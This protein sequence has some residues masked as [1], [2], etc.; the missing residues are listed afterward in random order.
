MA[1][2][3]FKAQM[4]DELGTNASRRLRRQGKLP[5]TVYGNDKQAIAIAVD[6]NKFI[7]AERAG[8]LFDNKLQLDIDGKI[9]TV[10]VKGVQRHPFKPLFLHLD[11][12]RA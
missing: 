5:A 11:F 8:I 1:N 7:E 12:L 10:V 9:E 3:T 4:R 2:L 6:Q